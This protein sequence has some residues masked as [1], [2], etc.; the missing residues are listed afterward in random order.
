MDRSAL[1]RAR[2]H[3]RVSWQR[4]R[5]SRRA[6]SWDAG[7]AGNP[8]LVSTIDAVVAEARVEPGMT[9][10][11]MGCGSGQLT[12][13]L[14]RVAAEVIA[15]D[16]SPSMIELLRRN[17][18]RE[19]VQNVA[20]R[21]EALE[22]LSAEPASLDLV[23]SNYALHHLADEDKRHL[24]GAVAGW[25]RPGGRLVIG[26]L[27]LGRGTDPRD[28]AVIREKLVTLGRRGPGGWW[29]IAKNTWRFTA[30]TAERPLSMNSWIHL[31][32]EAGFVEVTAQSVVSEAAVVSGTRPPADD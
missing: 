8:G 26:D 11:D 21:L 19:R 6:K 25:L 13:P 3:S 12:I 7:A 1:G 5:W 27:M 16:L 2:V 4:R 10:L 17:L 9:V 32:E 18:E 29:R 20:C 30:R 15:V 14:A 28:R 24:V 22:R 23:V 31:L